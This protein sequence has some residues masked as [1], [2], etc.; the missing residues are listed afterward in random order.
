MKAALATIATLTGVALLGL[1]LA[2][3]SAIF[4]IGDRDA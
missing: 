3:A 1:L 2:F 4:I